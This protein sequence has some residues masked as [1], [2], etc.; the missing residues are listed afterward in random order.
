MATERKNIGVGTERLL[1]GITA[2]RCEFRGCNKPLYVHDVTGAVENL[3]EKAHIYAVSPRG[4]RYI[5]QYE[6]KMF[7]SFNYKDGQKT[8]TFSDIK[9]SDLITHGA[10]KNNG[11]QSGPLFF[12]AWKGLE[13][14]RIQKQ[15][16]HIGLFLFYYFSI[17]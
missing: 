17:S 13:P 8:I 2:G 1:W 7:L 15:V 10:Q 16:D 9:G 11:S 4:A 12:S 5:E 6:D 3:A 14:E